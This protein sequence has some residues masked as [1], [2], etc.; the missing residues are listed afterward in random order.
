MSPSVTDDDIDKL[1]ETATG[2][3]VG[4]VADVE[5]E[6]AYVDLDPDVADSTRAA[7]DW[8]NT[9]GG[10]VPLA[11]ASIAEIT[12]DAVR[13]GG[14]FSE[15]HDEMGEMDE[16]ET[17]AEGRREF[18]QDET[19]TEPEGK[20]TSGTESQA[21]AGRQDET[22]P[23]PADLDETDPELDD[24]DGSDPGIEE[25][26]AD[27]GLTDAASEIDGDGERRADPTTDPLE[28]IGEGG[29]TEDPA[30]ESGT[31]EDVDIDPNEVIGESNAEIDAEEDV[32]QR[33]ESRETD[34]G[35]ERGESTEE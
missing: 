35:S 10:M 1:V 11:S 6:T 22:D 8:G 34:R 15:E 7:L 5:G 30:T 32:G 21:G 18:R 19:D 14:E 13:L 16:T 27:A 17:D 33:T 9:S 28:G 29:A 25:E 24:F 31:R 26:T 4:T 12:A 20:T 23:E 3:P 2:E